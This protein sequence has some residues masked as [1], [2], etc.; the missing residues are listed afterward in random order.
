MLAARRVVGRSGSVS[1]FGRLFAR[2]TAGFLSRASFR[3]GRMA[4]TTAGVAA[5][6]AM[7]GLAAPV[8]AQVT[9]APTWSQQSP[10]T[11]PPAR[12]EAT[13]AYDANSGLVVLFGGQGNNSL[14][15]RHLDV[16]WHHLEPAVP[17]HESSGERVCHDG[18]R[19]QLRPGGA[20]WRRRQ[21]RPLPGATPGRGMAQPGAS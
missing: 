2:Q 4:R 20:F 21:Q 18:V 7:M 12:L 6:M 9:P 13:M 1:G 5:V 16:E 19:C 11:S 8:C 14:L 3:P 15:G 17:G 10:A